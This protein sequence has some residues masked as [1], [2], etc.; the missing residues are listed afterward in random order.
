[1]HVVCTL[2]ARANGGAKYVAVDKSSRSNFAIVVRM[3][4]RGYR[5][6]HQESSVKLGGE[7]EKKKTALNF[8]SARASS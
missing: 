2:C 5:H 8:G 6:R 3:E 7:G 4:T 1:M